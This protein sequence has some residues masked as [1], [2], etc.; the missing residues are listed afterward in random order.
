[1]A[2]DLRELGDLPRPGAFESAPYYTSEGDCLFWFFRDQEHYA[3]RIDELV[4][5]YRAFEGGGI[6]GVQIK[7]VKR[8]LRAARE[9]L[10][11]PSDRVPLRAVLFG[12]NREASSPLDRYRALAAEVGDRTINARELVGT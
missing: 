8:L 12:A 10:A 2:T 7:G 4:T 11:T 5:V 3:E 1:M 9:L 6:V